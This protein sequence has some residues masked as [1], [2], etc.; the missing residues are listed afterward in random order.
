VREIEKWS[1]REWKRKRVREVVKE[2][3]RELEK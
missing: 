1:K 2:R 3:K